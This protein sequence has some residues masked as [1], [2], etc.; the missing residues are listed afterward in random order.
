MRKELAQTYLQYRSALQVWRELEAFKEKEQKEF[1]YFNFLFTELEEAALKPGEIEALEQELGMLE[2]AGQVTT[3][4]Q[5]VNHLLDSADQPVT[6]TIRSL[7]HQLETIAAYHPQISSL[8]ERLRSAQI[9]LKDI[10][11]ETDRIS[12][13]VSMDESRQQ[14]VNDRLSVVS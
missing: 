13:G 12:S 6:Q 11:D 8:A 10:A 14:E 9:E 3:V 1:D 4:L 2:H 5:R 7:V